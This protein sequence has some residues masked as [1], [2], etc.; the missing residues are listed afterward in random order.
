[1]KRNN[2]WQARARH[3]SNFLLLIF[4]IVRGKESSSV[5]P[6]KQLKIINKENMNMVRWQAH[7]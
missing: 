3:T 5:I 7:R 6:L 2:P 4:V 1:M